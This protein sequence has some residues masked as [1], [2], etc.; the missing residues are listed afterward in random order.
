MKIQIR[1]KYQIY[2]HEKII[3]FSEPVLRLHTLSIRTGRVLQTLP[4]YRTRSVQYCTPSIRTGR[5]L[6]TLPVYRTRSV[7]YC[8]PSIRTGR[9]PQ[10]L[11]VY[12]TR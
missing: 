8:I 9:V 1:K 6:Q 3:E 2:Y 5:V 12:R 4:V 11:P 7:Q 10:T